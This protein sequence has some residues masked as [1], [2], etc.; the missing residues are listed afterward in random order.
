MTEF[1]REF[2]RT[3]RLVS[4]ATVTMVSALVV[5]CPQSSH[6]VWL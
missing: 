4:W 3:L 1:Q 6:W 5:V 2:I